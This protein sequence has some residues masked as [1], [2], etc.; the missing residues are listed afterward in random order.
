MSVTGLAYANETWIVREYEWSRVEVSETRLHRIVTRYKETKK[1][2]RRRNDGLREEWLLW[3]L[4][5][6]YI[7][8][9]NSVRTSQRT[10]S[11]SCKSKLGNDVP[12]IICADFW[13]RR[14]HKYVAL[15]K[16]GF[17]NP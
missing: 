4:E 1:K 6:V 3:G 16:F 7:V 8:Y 15:A 12:E 14:I 11:L 13:D 5:F 10:Q 9:K 2:K 17:F